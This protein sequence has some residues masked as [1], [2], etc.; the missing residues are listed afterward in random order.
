MKRYIKSLLGA[1]LF[2]LALVNTSCIEETEPTSVATSKQ[3]SES[4]SATE[5]L[6]MA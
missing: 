2:S 5:A 1:G 6:L 4:S 3:I